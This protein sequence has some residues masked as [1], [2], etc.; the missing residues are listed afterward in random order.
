MAILAKQKIPDYQKAMLESMS[1]SSG[2]PIST[3]VRDILKKEYEK[4][5]ENSI[6]NSSSDPLYPED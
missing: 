6:V 4:L 5:T 3:I 1:Q 2:N